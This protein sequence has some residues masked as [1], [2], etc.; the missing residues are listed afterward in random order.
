MKSW[1][2]K[3]CCVPKY[4][5]PHGVYKRSSDLKTIQRHYCKVWKSTYSASTLSPFKWQKKRHINHPLMELKCVAQR[6]GYCEWI[7]KRLPKS[8]CFWGPLVKN[9]IKMTWWIIPPWIIFNL[10]NFRPLNTRQHDEK[11][12][13]ERIPKG[14]QKTL[15]NCN[16]KVDQFVVFPTQI[17]INI[18]YFQCFFSALNGHVYIKDKAIKE[19]GG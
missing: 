4:S 6:Q 13:P 18:K 1:E 9:A 19:G 14:S 3:R 8:D 11:D 2:E 12:L 5:R 17:N 10:M 16:V 7:P 15:K